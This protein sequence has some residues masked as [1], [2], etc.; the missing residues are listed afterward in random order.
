MSSRC[1][2]EWKASASAHVLPVKYLDVRPNMSTDLADA[3]PAQL[4]WHSMMLQR[5]LCRLRAGLLDCG[6][7]DRRRS[8]A[9]RRRCIF[10][11]A[12]TLSINY[13]VLCKCSAWA[14]LRHQIW[15]K[16]Q[17]EVPA[18]M[19]DQVIHILGAS[20]DDGHYC[21]VLALAGSLDREEDKFWA[22]CGEL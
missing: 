3:F 1:R 17:E 12:A 16:S 22:K 18:L 4:Q 20:P 5:S 10:C 19:Y 14:D 21:A 8:A 13:H 2:H 7:M 15:Q 6:H 11:D 9:S